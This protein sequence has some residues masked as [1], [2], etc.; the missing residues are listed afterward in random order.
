MGGETSNIRSTRA[1]HA[2]SR[3]LFGCSCCLQLLPLLLRLFPWSLH[4]TCLN[5]YCAVV[6]VCNLS[7]A[8]CAIGV[9]CVYGAHMFHVYLM[10][11]QTLLMPE[12]ETVGFFLPLWFHYQHI[13]IMMQMHEDWRQVGTQGYLK[14]A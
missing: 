9:L 7:C 4:S 14:T 1:Y 2:P 8:V 10:D 5:I 6:C 12:T 11:Q 13:S 3:D